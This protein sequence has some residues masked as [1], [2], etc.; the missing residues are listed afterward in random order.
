MSVCVS[1]IGVL[2]ALLFENIGCFYIEERNIYR[3]L[4]NWGMKILLLFVFDLIINRCRCR[5]SVE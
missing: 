5:C 2:E 3:V 4:F 1:K